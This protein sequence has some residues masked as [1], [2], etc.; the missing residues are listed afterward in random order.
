MR[1]DVHLDSETRISVQWNGA[2]ATFCAESVVGGASG[3]DAP[4]TT[5]VPSHTYCR[6]RQRDYDGDDFLY[7][8][9][10]DRSSKTD[11]Y[12]ARTKNPVRDVYLHNE[13]CTGDRNTCAAAPHWRL[14]LV[15]GPFVGVGEATHCG[16]AWVRGTRGKRPKRQKAHTL[17]KLYNKPLYDW[18][19]RLRESFAPYLARV[20]G[21][22]YAAVYAEMGAAS[23]PPL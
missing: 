14:D 8:M 17:A 18:R 2:R 11:S 21:P 22:R 16:Q 4:A 15:L 23:P 1:Y 19:E 20:A 9:S 12:V 3:G 13:K 7:M 6:L 5:S 10:H